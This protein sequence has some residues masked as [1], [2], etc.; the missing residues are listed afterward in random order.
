M[1]GPDATSVKT[2]VDVGWQ[3]RQLSV[4]NCTINPE[5]EGAMRTGTVERRTNETEIIAAV[6]LDG[7]GEYGS[8][9]EMSGQSDLNTRASGSGAAIEESPSRAASGRRRA[10]SERRTPRA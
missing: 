4:K 6:Y 3:W 8:F 10:S 5:E 1:E 9:A 2:I 7:T